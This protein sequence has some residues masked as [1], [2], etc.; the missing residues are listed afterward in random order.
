MSEENVEL[1]RRL[2]DAWL[3]R[4]FGVVPE[5]MD[6]EVEYVNPPY[7]VEP[8]TR[9]GYDE[10]AAAADAVKAV[11]GDYIVSPIEVH[12]LGNRVVVRAHVTTESKGNA[13]P[14]AAQRGYVFDVHDG[15]ITRFMWFNDP[16]EALAAA[17][18]ES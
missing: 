18:E 12:D 3:E 13:V 17:Q 7:A 9:R 1:V 14:I 15:R 2:Y 11:Y 4:G 6:P 5:L 16:A 8:G 10:F